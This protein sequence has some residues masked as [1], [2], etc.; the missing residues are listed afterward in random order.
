MI[1]T[2]MIQWER[3]LHG[4]RVV[5]AQALWSRVTGEPDWLWESRSP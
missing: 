5:G 2:E 3:D 1:A 4:G